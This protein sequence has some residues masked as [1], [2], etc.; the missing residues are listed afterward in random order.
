MPRNTVIGFLG[1]QLDRAGGPG[2]WD[3][4]RPSIA[5]CQQDD[6][7]VDRFELLHDPKFLPLA[8]SVAADIRQISP[9][10]EVRLHALAIRDPWDFQDVYESLHDF[11]R[12]YPFD[13]RRESYFAHMT[14][15]T[16]VAQICLFLLTEA[17]FLPGKLLQTEPPRGRKAS[18]DPSAGRM[19]IIDLDLSKYDR[20]ATR[21]AKDQAEARDVLRSGIATRNKAFNQ[22][23]AEL[24][25][26]ALRSTAL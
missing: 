3:S 9:E 17:H 2:R 7:R 25:V 20:L 14:T 12:E 5:L 1:T 18:R 8:E 19:E 26:V 21:F 16:H 10:T 22:L 24:E 6:F 13:P 23:I 15:G 11:C 4:W